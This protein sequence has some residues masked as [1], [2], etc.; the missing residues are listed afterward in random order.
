[1]CVHVDAPPL[2]VF[3]LVSDVTNTGRFSPETFEAEWLGGATAPAVG[4][5]FRGHVRRNSRRWL[6]YWTNCTIT[7]CVP[8]RTFAFKV[9]APRGRSFVHWRYDLEPSAGGTDLTESFELGDVAGTGLYA[10]LAGRSRTRVNERNMRETLERIKVAAEQA[11]GP[12]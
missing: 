2:E 7:E 6:V 9:D 3:A 4:A 8:G 1:M 5:R 11:H 10:A 12:R